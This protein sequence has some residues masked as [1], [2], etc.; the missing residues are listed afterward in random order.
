MDTLY[1]RLFPLAF[2]NDGAPVTMSNVTRAIA[3][4]ERTIVSMRSPYDRYRYGADT[5]A[6]SAAAK[7]GEIFFFLRATREL[8]PVSRRLE[9]QRRRPLRGGPDIRA[10][11]VNTGLYN[12]AGEF[13]Y[14]PPNTGL[15]QFTNR[16]QDIGKFRAPTLRNI[17]VTAPYMRDGSIRTL[18]DVVDHYA[19]GGR[20]ITS[21]PYAGIGHDN[22]NKAPSVH[23][24]A[25]TATE[26]QD[27]IA[28]LET[29]TDSAFLRSTALSNPWK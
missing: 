29:L 18:S 7:R 13:P 25:F 19:A 23:G 26:K 12:V 24:F 28:F 15:F 5:N 14:P 9:F 10:S 6:I 27:L 22:W 11:F 20:T 17:A 3:A 8:P 16:V 21:G 1:Q 2:P 4:F